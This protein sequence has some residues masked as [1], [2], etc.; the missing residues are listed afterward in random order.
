M[1]KGFYIKFH[2]GEVGRKAKSLDHFCFQNGLV[3][4]E[5]VDADIP[6]VKGTFSPTFKRTQFPLALSWSCKIHKVQGLIL[7]QHQT[8]V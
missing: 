2:D 1:L 4:R 6:V 7:E 8:I 3:P 5:K